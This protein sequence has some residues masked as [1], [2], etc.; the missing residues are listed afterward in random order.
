M[1]GITW[2]DGIPFGFYAIYWTSVPG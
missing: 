1:A 2:W